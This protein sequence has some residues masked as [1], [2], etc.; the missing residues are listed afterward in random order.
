M[1]SS[2]R[3]LLCCVVP[4]LF[5]FT[6][7]SHSQF[8]VWKK[9]FDGQGLSIGINP[10]NPNT[11]YTQGNDDRLWVSRNRGGSWSSLPVVLPFEI[12]E[13]LIHPKDSLTIFVAN[14]SSQLKRSTD[15]GASW[16][17]V[18][19]GYGIDG[20]SVCLDPVHPDTM[21]AGNF[22]DAAIFRST[23]RG[24]SWAL[25]GH[26]GSNGLCALTVRPDSADILYAGS[27]NGTISKS[28]NAGQ[29]WYLVKTG[30]SQEIPR[31]V[32]D[33]SNPQVAYAAAFSGNLSADGV[34]KTVDGGEHWSLTALASV[35]M[36]DRYRP[37]PSGH[38][39]FGDVRRGQ[40]ERLPDDGRGGF[41][42][43]IEQGLPS[44]LRDVESQDR[45][46]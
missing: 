14:F 4:L 24:A 39:V 15:G 44:E 32:V 1:K 34:W 42:G 11:I 19:N 37:E 18:I 9:Q 6:S 28:T 8:S 40:R 45:S 23:D 36:V 26:A 16:S 3:V 38:G 5:L 41:V 13:I 46:A 31:I 20:E 27:G 2:L 12:R 22:S 35:S 10:L 25:K 30:G 43:A 33:P 17:N 29:S 7:Q 21:Y